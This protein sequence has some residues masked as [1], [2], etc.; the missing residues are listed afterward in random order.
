MPVLDSWLYSRTYTWIGS[1]KPIFYH[2]NETLV[3]KGIP[4]SPDSDNLRALETVKFIMLNVVPKETGS[5]YPILYTVVRQF[6]FEYLPND[7]GY[8]HF[9]HINERFSSHIKGKQAVLLLSLFFFPFVQGKFSLI[10]P[11]FFCLLRMKRPP[12]QVGKSFL[13]RENKHIYN[14]GFSLP[15]VLV[16]FMQLQASVLQF[17]QLNCS[18]RVCLYSLV[19][20]QTEN[21]FCLWAVTILRHNK[22]LPKKHNAMQDCFYTSLA[23]SSSHHSFV[24]QHNPIHYFSYKE[25]MTKFILEQRYHQQL[26]S[27]DLSVQSNQ[28]Q[29]FRGILHFTQTKLLKY[30]A[31]Q[32]VLVRPDTKSKF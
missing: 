9:W 23:S 4:Y 12:D 7:T 2:K 15:N 30:Y 27:Y 21:F 26:H 29:K 6:I 28:G 22:H 11:K 10:F 16:C 17:H 25:F 24:C 18:W 19:L 3:N 8:H 13:I 1:F 5:L 31:K 20:G 14:C 32:D